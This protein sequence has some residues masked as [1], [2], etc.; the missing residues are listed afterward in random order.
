[1]IRYEATRQP[2][3]PIGIGNVSPRDMTDEANGLRWPKLR[4]LGAIVREVYRVIDGLTLH[5][6]LLQ[7]D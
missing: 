1:M 3:R 7:I 2:K 4:H 5:R 6:H